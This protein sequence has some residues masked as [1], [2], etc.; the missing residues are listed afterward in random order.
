MP[1]DSKKEKGSYAE[2]EMKC[3]FRLNIPKSSE[4][5]IYPYAGS[6]GFPYVQKYG[7]QHQMSKEKYRGQQYIDEQ[8]F[9]A[10]QDRR[11]TIF[12]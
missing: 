10:S 12:E 4:F 11:H 2:S 9:P 1:D 6:D 7:V 5:S 3:H 8:I